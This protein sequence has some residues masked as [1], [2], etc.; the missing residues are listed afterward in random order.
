[1]RLHVILFLALCSLTSAHGYRIL[2]TVF[3]PAYSHQ[4]SFRPI[5]KALA[6]K[7]HDLVLLTT[8][9]ETEDPAFRKIRQIDLSGS[10]EVQEK[11]GASE[12]L[13]QGNN[14]GRGILDR[15]L[16]YW[17]ALD[18]VADWQLSHP[19]VKALIQNKSENFD[20]VVTEI[21]NPIHMG[22]AER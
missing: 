8:N 19:E 5:W 17:D 20:L 9:P 14:G 4:S 22:F 1:M 6:D 16:G 2:A 15:V 10:Y 18:A 3:T 11:H 12:I 13:S 7:G 21:M